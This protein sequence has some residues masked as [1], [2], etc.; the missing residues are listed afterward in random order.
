[1]IGGKRAFLK[2]MKS[3]IGIIFFLI[4]FFQDEEA[5]SILKLYNIIKHNLHI[6]IYSY[7][8]YIKKKP[9]GI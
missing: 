5:S 7:T 4:N 6:Y 1:M 3:Q 9:L 8:S 2:I